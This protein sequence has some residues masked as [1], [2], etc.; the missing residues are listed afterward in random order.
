MATFSQANRPM[1]VDTTLGEDVLLLEGLSGTEAV[2]R[3]FDCTL[4]LLSTDQGIDGSKLLRTPMRVT[5]KLADGGE[6]IIHGLVRRFTTLGRSED[7]ASYRAEVVPWLWFLSLS[8]DCKIFQKMTVPEIVEQVFTSQGYSDFEFKL[9][10]S[11]PQRLFCVQYRESHLNFVSRLLEEEGIFYFFEH[12]KDKH[13]LKLVDDN[14]GVKPCPGQPTAHMAVSAAPWREQDVVVA[15]EREDAVHTGKVTLRDYDPEQPLLQLEGSAAGKEPEEMYAYPGRYTTLDEGERY[16]RLQLEAEEA[17]RHVVRGVGSCRAFQPG[18]RFDLKDHF[19]RDANQTY[20]LLELRYSAQAGDYRSWDSATFDYRIDFLAVPY[21]VPYRPF[22]VTPKP[23]VW[24]SQPA[25]VVGPKGEEIWTD[26]FGRIKV[27][28]YWDRLGKKDENSSCWIRVSQ[29]WAGKG[30][31]SLAIPRIGQEVIVEFLE[32]D[33]DLPIISGKVYNAD[34]TPPY[35]PAKGGVVSGL[36]SNTHKGKGYNEMSMNDTAGKEMITI[37]AQYDM[38]T[39]VEH[40]DTQ[41]VVSGNRKIDVKA[42]THTETIKGDTTINVTA[43]KQ[44]NTVNKSIDITSQTAYIHLKAETEIQLEVGASK[45]LMKKDG[46]I[47]LTGVDIGVTGSKSV[48]IKG[49]IVHSQADSEHQTKGA[50]VMS[51]GSA[52]N[53]IKGGMVMLNP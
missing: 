45:L 39:T 24:G 11:Y 21:S 7:L 40:D 27:Q 52:T 13:V 41:T 9:V 5:V 8:S 12:S 38:S 31:G 37:H 42:G 1:R 22:R 50:V 18:Y 34:Q 19:R 25:I 33:P 47:S 49:G 44:S 29:P 35:D 51:E 53:T 23:R 30:W 4:D 10:K 6:R 26:K 46:T 20:M 32:G 17:Q 3:P 15:C 2:S 28:F 43:G 14:S 48:T 36:R 16:A